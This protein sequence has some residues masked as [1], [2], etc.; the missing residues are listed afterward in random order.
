VLRLSAQQTVTA[1]MST[2]LRS[3]G[4]LLAAVDRLMICGLAALI[5]L[6]PLAIGAV[7][8]GSVV[9]MQLTIFTLVLIAMVRSTISR[10]LV[11]SNPLL[12]R[13]ARRLAFPVISIAVLLMVQLI[14]IPPQ[15]LRLL[16]PATYHV[17][18]IAFPGWPYTN[19]QR[20]QSTL[21]TAETVSSLSV[22]VT[23]ST[24]LLKTPE[25]AAKSITRTPTS[26]RST[27]YPVET[28][29]WRPLTLSP[30]ATSASLL[31]FLALASVFFLVLVF[32]FKTEDRQS[33]QIRFVRVIILPI[34]TTGAVIALLGIAERAWWNGRILWFYQP[35]DW[36]GPLLIDS[37]RAS[38][39]FVNPDHFANYLA[40]SLPLAVAGALFP[41]FILPAPR[42]ER[43]NSRLLFGCAATLML[44]G[45]ALSLS[46]GGWL[47]ICVGVTTTLAMCFRKTS[48]LALAT[49]RRPG[50][51]AVPRAIV[52]FAMM[53]GLTLYV[54]GGPARS[55]VGT[56]MIT[57]SASDFSAR[58]G[59]WQETLTMIRDFP[60]F[61]V[62]AGAWPEIFPHY[63]PPPESHYHFFRTAENDYL[64]FVAENGIAGLI[65]MLGLVMLM[66]RAVAAAAARMPAERWPLFAGLLGGLGA[67]LVQEFVDSSLHIPANALLFTVLLALLLRV[68]LLTEPGE[69]GAHSHPALA[70]RRSALEWLLA[71]ASIVLMIAAWNQDGRAYPY[72]VEHPA[73]LMRAG[74]NLV[75][76][77]AM[78]AVH[79]D[80]A[81][82]MVD[83]TESQRTE[84]SGAVWLDPNEPFARDL[85][86]RDLLLAGRK[87]EALAQLSESVYRAPFLDL[88]YYLAPSAIPWLLPEE[89]QAIARG[90]SL[91]IDHNFGDAARYLA[92]FYVQ[93]GRERDAATAY[94]H[95]ARVTSDPS[96]R[97]NLLLEAGR[98][99]ARMHDYA[100]GCKVLLGARSLAPADPRPYLELAQNI[101]GPENNLAAATAIIDQGITAGA[102]PYTL[103][104]ALAST[105]EM[106]GRYQIAEGAL[107]RAQAY[108][109]SFDV[110]LRL[111]RVYFAEDRFPR[112]V[113]TLH[114]AVELNPSSAE[115]F[116]WLGR[117]YESTYDYYHAAG[118]F[119]HA[120][121]LAP[122]D[123]GLRAQYRELEHRLGELVTPDEAHW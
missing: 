3:A 28:R 117:A 123:K 92:S 108:D 22:S 33:A 42:R 120:M 31:E 8:R 43:F 17:Y 71:P 118:A 111:G 48:D 101:Y 20:P 44:I 6:P 93:L 57:T 79:L 46:R 89:Q 14:A 36:N 96:D 19:H 12:K 106:N 55:T 72:F 56:R 27:F 88:H 41:A 54:I 58:V 52:T 66:T 85:L 24:A 110:T 16:S 9:A 53:A 114:H 74:D 23:K 90:F 26:P 11:A 113:G 29:E 47:A 49:P 15:V 68:A 70:A 59:A 61:G 64:Q 4:R 81:R 63:Q 98:E 100:N 86:A 25:L 69:G 73:D 107:A 83:A 105:A 103:E 21:S 45:A 84:L 121:L 7:N 32:P 82:M 102:D 10:I 122:G 77:P 87:S 116:S 94:E 51:G 39:P 1:T 78:S 95:G 112:A 67:G 30:A 37:P 62:G 104:M 99:Y 60:V 35:A 119:R 109:P 18:R 80:F 34:I 91:A 50:L 75:E 115:A 65:M 13:E 5:A 76:H 40:L 38:G 97:L 2:T